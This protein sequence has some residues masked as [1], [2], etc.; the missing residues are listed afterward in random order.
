MLV[1]YSMVL[2]NI[3]CDWGYDDSEDHIVG[4]WIKILIFCTNIQKQ[5]YFEQL[6][7]KSSFIRVKLLV[8]SLLFYL[9]KLWQF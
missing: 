9:L 3:C 1:H 8:L 7:Y 5:G 4:R 6:N 2:D